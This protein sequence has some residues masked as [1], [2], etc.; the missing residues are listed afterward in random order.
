[1]FETLDYV[2]TSIKQKWRLK[3]FSD[4][5]EEVLIENIL[6]DDGKADLSA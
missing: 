4:Q 3:K 2:L 5:R 6:K 1:M